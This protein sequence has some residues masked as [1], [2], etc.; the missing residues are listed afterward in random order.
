MIRLSSN[1]FTTIPTFGPCTTTLTWII[2]SS[3]PIAHISPYHVREFTN[4]K[5]LDLMNCEIKA[6]PM[7]CQLGPGLTIQ[8]Q[9]NP[10]VCDCHAKE[11]K[12]AADQGIVQL[13]GNPCTEPSQLTS[14]AMQDISMD[15][16]VCPEEGI[17]Q[18]H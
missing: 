3:N 4:L 15:M 10:L 1:D 18:L 8:L 11:L 5:T 17:N 16:F 7:L 12:L 9:T 14:L 13:S 2:L 6:V